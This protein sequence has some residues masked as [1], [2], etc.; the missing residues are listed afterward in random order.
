MGIGGMQNIKV[1]L[2][3]S[4]GA[5]AGFAHVGVLLV[6]E[7]EGI[8]IDMVA[9]TSTGA[10]IGALYAQGKSAGEIKILITDLGRKRFSYT[11]KLALAKTRLIRAKQAKNWL[12]TLVGDS[13]FEDLV[14]PFACVATDIM[15]GEEVIIDQ[16]SVVEGVRASGSFPVIVPLY[17]WQG[18]YVVDGGLVNPVPVSV[19]KRMGADFIIAVNAI[20]NRCKRLEPGNRRPNVFKLMKQAFYISRY[21][22]V[23]VG[24]IG[25]D[26]V[27]EP[28]VAHISFGD[29]HRTEECIRQGELAAQESIVDLKRQLAANK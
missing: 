27:I 28:Q 21:Q 10:L 29:F 26:L 12:G 25:A 15:T 24:L 5:A 23:R 1:G 3:L 13:E 2:A 4:S 6:L 9:G 16:G 22:A 17:K 8:P 19:L 11:V 18:R 20:T 7:K 14:I